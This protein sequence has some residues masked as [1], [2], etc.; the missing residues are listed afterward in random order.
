M[1]GERERARNK[2]DIRLSPQRWKRYQLIYY[3]VGD[4]RI[5]LYVGDA[6]KLLLKGEIRKWRETSYLDVE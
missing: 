1:G 6:G 4:K 5:I 3:F 2:L